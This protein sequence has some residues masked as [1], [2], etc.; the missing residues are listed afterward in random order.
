MA[1][2]ITIHPIQGKILYQLLLKPEARFSELNIDKISNDHF[3]F[4]I[5]RLIS[6]NLIKKDDANKYC[7]TD[8]GKE[9]ANRL[10]TDRLEIIKQGKIAVFV[11]C[12]S[13]N[14]NKKQYLIQQRFQHPYYGFYGFIGGKVK[15]GETV[16]EAAERYLYEEAGLKARLQLVGIRHKIDYSTKQELLEDKYY[17]V[18]K[19]ID[20]NGVLKET[21]EKGK[22]IWMR[23]EEI[24]KEKNLL[25]G[26]DITLEFLENDALTFSEK[27]YK[28]DNY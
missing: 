25:S 4:H 2:E 22:H 7:L 15:W 12:I 23:Y 28:E 20:I 18:F 14:A 11:G 1:T 21:F 8:K 3:T 6:E 13:L 24:K 9:F 10:D 27:K 5:N 17:F 19:G 16:Y 26:M